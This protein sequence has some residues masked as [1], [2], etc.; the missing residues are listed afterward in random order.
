MSFLRA[1]VARKTSSDSML[2]MAYGF[3]FRSAGMTFVMGSSKYDIAFRMDLSCAADH[4]SSLPL[5]FADGDTWTCMEQPV[6]S[7]ISQY[8]FIPA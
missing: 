8:F 5:G 4:F 7:L 3:C 6:V 2:D 1:G